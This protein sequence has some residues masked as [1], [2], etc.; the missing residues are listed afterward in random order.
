MQVVMPLLV[1]VFMCVESVAFRYF[2]IWM[3]KKEE[4][5]FLYQGYVMAFAALVYVFMS[6]FTFDLKLSSLCLA[7]GFGFCLLGAT[8]GLAKGYTYGSMSL[9][10]LLNSASSAIPILYGWLFLKE[11]LTPLRIAGYAALALTFVLSQEKEEKKHEGSFSFRWM[12]WVGLAFAS[13]G[14]ASILMNQYTK[15]DPES[16][17]DMFM[18]LCYLTAAIL[19]F[20]VC[21]KQKIHFSIEGG[22]KQKYLLPVFIMVS[23]IGG[24]TANKLLLILHAK[25]AASLLVP[26]VNGAQA[27]LITIISVCIFGEKLSRRKIGALAAGIAAIVL[28]QM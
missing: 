8:L 12:A 28:L 15:I 9:T 21:R 5:D 25:V 20:L 11:A 23:G 10:N 17:G 6:G 22:K 14:I 13:S 19:Y 4:E 16:N 27:V 24:L 26:L 18:A 3:K 7:A 2:Q 1:A